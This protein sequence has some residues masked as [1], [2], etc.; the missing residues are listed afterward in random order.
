MESIDL[1]F[2]IGIQYIQLNQG[3]SV[4]EYGTIPDLN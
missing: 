4:A 1:F 3:K 2:K